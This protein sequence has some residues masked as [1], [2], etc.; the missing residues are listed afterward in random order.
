MSTPGPSRHS[1]HDFCFFGPNGSLT[2]TGDLVIESRAWR[3]RLFAQR[4]EPPASAYPPIMDKINDKVR[5]L[6]P[7]IGM[8]GG[9]GGMAL[10]QLLVV[11]DGIDE[12]PMMRKFFTN[13]INTF[14]DAMFVIPRKVGPVSLRMRPPKP[15]AGADLL[16]RCLQRPDRAC[17]TRHSRAPGRM[18]R[19]IWFR[20]PTKNDRR[21]SST[22]T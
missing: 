8:G 7:G 9:G 2:P 18:G 3:E 11:M 4:A 1:I 6:Y 12:P 13:R 14:L 10:N 5:R 20:T 22:C 19:H 17:S 16:H 21:T 15:R